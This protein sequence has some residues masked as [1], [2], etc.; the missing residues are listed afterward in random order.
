MVAARQRVIVRWVHLSFSLLLGAFVYSPLAA[1][2]IF[3]T[4]IRGLVFPAMTMSG[5]YM[6]QQGRINKL[7]RG[8]AR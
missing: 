4:I 3:A 5:I 7:A 1:D 2:P 6:W 8:G